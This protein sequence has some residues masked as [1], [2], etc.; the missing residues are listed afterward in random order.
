MNRNIKTDNFCI[1]NG[2]LSCENYFVPIKAI[3]MVRLDRKPRKSYKQAVIALLIGIIL[4]LIPLTREFGSLLIIIGI[5]G[6]IVVLLNNLSKK[7]YLLV[8]LN[9]GTVCSFVSEDEKFLIKVMSVL[10]GNISG[11]RTVSAKADFRKG[12]IVII[13]DNSIRK[14]TIGN[15]SAGGNIDFG[16]GI[17]NSTNKVNVG[18]LS[19]DEWRLLEELFEE[20]SDKY[21]IG[22]KNRRA[23]ESMKDMAEKHDAKSLGTTI[24]KIA[25][26]L[27]DKAM[28][29]LLSGVTQTLAEQVLPVLKKF[30]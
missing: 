20:K 6:T 29:I 4:A 24:K 3:S 25:S 26:Q 27:G 11:K 15:I 16:N 19:D 14:T 10:E 12:N 13:N 8:T 21:A 22:S 28:T 5:I 30:F 23:Y 18:E 1:E 7:R 17:G 2:I 9:N